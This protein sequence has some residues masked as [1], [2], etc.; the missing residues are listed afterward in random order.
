MTTT[1]RYF[2]ANGAA[3]QIGMLAD[4][5]S[6]IVRLVAQPSV[7]QFVLRVALAVPF[8]RSGILKWEGFLQ[9]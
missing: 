5:L 6:G 8:W 7:V 9:V 1:N 2:A 4:R 3:L